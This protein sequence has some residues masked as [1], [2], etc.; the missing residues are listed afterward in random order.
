VRAIIIAGAGGQFSAGSTDE[1]IDDIAAYDALLTALRRAPQVIIARVEGIALGGGLGLICAADIAIATAETRCAAPDVRLG[2]VPGAIMPHLMRRVGPSRARELL[3]MG[4]LFDGV[5]AHEYGLVQY[6]CPAESLNRVVTALLDE[7]R[8][9]SPAALRASKQ[10]LTDLE[11][12]PTALLTAERSRAEQEAR[13]HPDAAEGI[14]AYE[15][16][17]SARWSQ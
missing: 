3:L 14:D 13:A 12:Q 17:R 8:Q 1:R 16:G 4:R 5:S 10:L 6:V 11:E 7:L 9:C 15:M 2:L